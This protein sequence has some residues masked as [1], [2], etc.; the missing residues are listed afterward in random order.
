MA[1]CPAA[2]LPVV[3]PAR[4]EDYEGIAAVQQANGL[5]PK[6]REE[7]E[8]LWA[9]NPALHSLADWPIG[10]VLEDGA[11]GIVGSIGN[12]PFLW[13]LGDKVL[14]CASGHGWS[15]RPAYRGYSLLL[16]RRY[17][18]Q[19]GVDLLITTSPSAAVAALFEKMGWSRVPAGRW[20]RAAL[21]ITGYRALARELAAAAHARALNRGRTEL[22]FERDAPPPV[23]AAGRDLCWRETFDSSFDAFWTELRARHPR[24]LW[25][26]RNRATLEWHFRFGLAAGRVRILTALKGSRLAAY[27]IFRLRLAANGVRVASVADLQMLEPNPALCRALMANAARYC[28]MQGIALIEN[29]GCCLESE[30]YLDRSAPYH[31]STGTW[32][33]LYKAASASLEADLRDARRWQPTQ[34]DGDA[35]L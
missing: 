30:A 15:V 32:L 25:S 17:L 29:A 1:A 11:A 19:P 35:M 22:R 28:R 26:A 31:R 6:S 7:W 24:L 16:L 4:F 23:S 33:Y 13:H 10:W 20:D 3:R 12:L 21:W 18:G 14:V 27:A 8:H 34:F 2:G 9:G 5:T